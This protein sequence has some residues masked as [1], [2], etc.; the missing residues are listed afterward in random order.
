MVELAIT[1]HWWLERAV[2]YVQRN[3]RGL[4]SV[5]DGIGH[6]L[7]LSIW[8]SRGCNLIFGTYQLLHFPVRLFRERHGCVHYDLECQPWYRLPRPR[9][10]PV[11]D[12]D[13]FGWPYGPNQRYLLQ[14]GRPQRG[15]GR[16]RQHDR[17][18]LS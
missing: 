7:R 15:L 2:P 10:D 3:E 18:V 16:N 5:F 12:R 13:D 6:W 14:S 17:S 11:G 9:H 8:A 1:G 4:G